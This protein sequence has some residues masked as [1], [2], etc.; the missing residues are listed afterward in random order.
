MQISTTLR[1]EE[2]DVEFKKKK[3]RKKKKEKKMLAWVC[4]MNVVRV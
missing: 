3:R 4:G 2:Y 1:W